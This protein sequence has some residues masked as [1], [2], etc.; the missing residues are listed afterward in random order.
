MDLGTQLTPLSASTTGPGPSRDTTRSRTA[1]MLM[2]VGPLLLLRSRTLPVPTLT[3]ELGNVGSHL[4][5]HFAQPEASTSGNGA[6]LALN[7]PHRPV[8]SVLPTLA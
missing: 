2:Y 5:F 8:E 7:E 4:P 3:T 6:S 1:M